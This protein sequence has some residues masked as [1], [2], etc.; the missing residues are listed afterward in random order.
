MRLWQPIGVGLIVALVSALGVSSARAAFEYRSVPFGGSLAGAWKRAGS[1]APIARQTAWG[2]RRVLAGTA[3]LSVAAIAVNRRGRFA[4]AGFEADGRLVAGTTVLG[5]RRATRRTLRL[6]R[7][8]GA[9]AVAIDDSGSVVVAWLQAVRGGVAVYAARARR[10]A[11]GRPRR[12]GRVAGTVGDL[13]LELAVGQTGRAALA[14]GPTGGALA[15]RP[16][17]TYVAL[18][19]PGR[20]FGPPRRLSKASEL[21][22]I[23]DAAGTAWVGLVLG[24][25]VEVRSSP[26]DGER[27]GAP[28]IFAAPDRVAQLAFAAGRDGTV[29]AGWVADLPPAGQGGGELRVAVREAG[30][31]FAPAETVS[32]PLGAAGS[33]SFHRATNPALAVAPDGEV[34]AAWAQDTS[35]TGLQVAW[36]ARRAG[37][38]FAPAQLLAQ[39]GTFELTLQL[40]M[41]AR[42]IAALA[43]DAIDETEVLFT[44]LHPHGGSFSRIMQLRSQED[45]Q[46]LSGGPVPYLVFARP[47]GLRVRAAR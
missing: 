35:A 14:V 30:M 25:A 10:G 24:R 8:A 3:P 23:V 32:R 19:A 29:A 41:A 11:F 13:G 28:H 15:S 6:G 4:F 43:Y 45:G 21:R 27:F 33:E 42:G 39:T 31:S 37:R 38:P 26:A 1:E 22:V 12:V 7:R 40:A 9:P 46:L 47:G 34:L 16:E 20:P 44:A 36:T 17:R 2:P 18:A 5:A